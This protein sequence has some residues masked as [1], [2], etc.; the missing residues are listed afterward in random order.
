MILDFRFWILDWGQTER[1]NGS[2]RLA[3][4]TGNPLAGAVN[5]SAPHKRACSA[6]SARAWR[7][8][9]LRCLRNTAPSLASRACLRTLSAYWRS[10]VRTSAERLRRRADFSV[11]ASRSFAVASSMAIVFIRR[12]ISA[13]SDCAQGLRSILL[14]NIEGNQLV[15]C[16]IPSSKTSAVRFR[17]SRGNGNPGEGQRASFQR[18]LVSSGGGDGTWIPACAGMTKTGRLF[19]NESLRQ[20]TRSLQ[21][22]SYTA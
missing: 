22:D 17:H 4:G 5:F 21:A 14:A 11:S 6:I 1:R 13:L 3:L 10:A 16:F 15:S 18:R 19:F 12:I 9:T 20:D 2:R 7:A 8:R